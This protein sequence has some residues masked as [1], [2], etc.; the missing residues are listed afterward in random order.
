MPAKRNLKPM[1]R[2]IGDD[3]GIPY[4]LGRACNV[5]KNAGLIDQIEELRRKVL[6][7]ESKDKAYRI[8]NRYFYLY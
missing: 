4:I 1:L 3:A 5:L 6:S 2:V 7:A 8:L